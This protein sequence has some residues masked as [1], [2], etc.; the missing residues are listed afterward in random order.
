MCCG[1]TAEQRLISKK[2]INKLMRLGY[3]I[4]ETYEG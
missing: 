4:N 1:A 2:A 3:Q